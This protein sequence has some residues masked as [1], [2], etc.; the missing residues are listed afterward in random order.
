MASGKRGLGKI[1]SEEG[2]RK[3]G[4]LRYSYSCGGLFLLRKS[5]F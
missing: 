5:H 2:L 4:F 3:S 1:E